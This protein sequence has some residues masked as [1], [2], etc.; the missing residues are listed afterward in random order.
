MTKRLFT[1]APVALSGAL[2]LSACAGMSPA[3]TPFTQDGLPEAVKVPAGHQVA[4]HTVGK[5]EITYECKAK[6]D[7]PGSFVWTFIGPKADLMARNGAKVGTYYGPPATWESTDGSRLT[8]TQL[9][10]APSGAANLPLQLVKANP[11]MGTG[12]MTGISHI[13]RLATQGGVA[14]ASPCEAA[15]AGRRQVVPYQADYVFWKAM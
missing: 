10:V 15:F 4:M 2:L 5:G 9:A 8:G 14:P 12:A 3:G 13:Q 7:A 1:A 6:A 11:A